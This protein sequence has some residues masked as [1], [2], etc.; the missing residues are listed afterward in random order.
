MKKSILNKDIWLSFRQSKGRFLS[1]MSLMMLGAFALVGLKT[2]S[3]D[4]EGSTSRYLAGLNTM[5]LALISDYG[6]S[7]EDQKELDQIE[8]AQVEYAYFADAVIGDSHQALRVFSKPETISKFKLVSGKYPSNDQEIALLSSF[9]DRYKIGDKIS[10]NEKSDSSQVLTQHSFTITGFV[11]SGEL[12]STINF[13]NTDVGSGTLS[14]YA[15]VLPQV[16]DSQVYTVARLTYDDL[17]GLNSFGDSYRTKLE[18]HQKALEDLVADNA[19][20]RL[21]EIQAEAQTKIQDGE[22]G[23][24]KAQQSLADA[25]NQLTDGQNQ[26]NQKQAELNQAQSQITENQGK[27]AQAASQLAAGEETLAASKAQLDEAAPQI[28][29]GQNQLAQ[30][31]AQLD[32][33]AAPLTAAQQT[34]DG[35]KAELDAAQSSLSQGQSQLAAAQSQLQAQIAAIEAQGGNPADFP[36]IAAA[37]QALAAKEAELAAGQQVLEAGQSQYQAALAQYQPQEAAYQAALGQYQEAEAQFNSKKAAYDAGLSQYQAGLASLES[38]KAEYQSGLSQLNQAK[39]QLAE[40]Q[41]QLDQAQASL[42]EKKAEFA[43]QKEKAEIQI[44]NSQAEIAKAKEDAAGL[45]LPTYHVYSRRTFPGDTEYQTTATRA[46]GISSV[47]NIFPIVL[48]LVAALVTMTTMTR[49]VNEERGNAGILRALGYKNKDVIK[50]FL[51]YGLISGVLGT[52][53]GILAGTYFLPYI[54]GRSLFQTATYPPLRLDFYWPISLLALAASLVCSVLPALYIAHKELKEKP[55]QLL[56]PKPPTKGSS[57]LLEKIG[58]IW[59]RLSFTQK[60]TAR[61]IFRYK[62][63]MFMTIFG[64]AG[65][66]ALL[67][68]GLGISSSLGGIA[69]RQFGDILQYDMVVVQK[70]RAS[71][72]EEKDLA[73]ALKSDKIS[74]SQGIYRETFSKTIKGLKDEQSISLFVSE[75]N[76]FKGFAELYDSQSKQEMKLSDDGVIISRKLATLLKVSVGDSFEL[77]SDEGKTYSLKVSGISEMYAGHF[78]FMNQAYYEKIF[79]QDFAVNAYL[80]KLKNHSN[81]DIQDQAADFMKETG[82]QTVVQ[83]LDFT[84]QI[85]AAVKSLGLVMQILTLVSILLAVVILYNLT[86]INVAERIRELS[87]IKVLGFHNKEVTLYIYRETISLSLIGILVGIFAGRALHSFLLQ[88]IAPDA[89]LFNPE[90]ALRVY[91]IPIVSIIAILILLGFMVNHNLRRVDMLEALKSVD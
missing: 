50:K 13:G 24:E 75:T 84:E 29:A 63:R 2:A 48:Y 39:S 90:V 34:L 45:L 49:F 25:Q 47:G 67:F 59:R 14:G 37:Q 16:F 5:D 1:I 77:T 44:K 86:N 42:D 27:L 55:A 10:L 19:E 71:Q 87:T 33:V 51:V 89:I 30:S 40:G 76:D 38:R 82:V 4:I 31:K 18:K 66:V 85:N 60:V 35:K 43:K 70:N 74:G 28:A 81:K 61:N 23:V 9:Q 21:E 54:L 91:L 64:V 83:N 53:L 57:I 52:I 32:A 8:G 26:I 46:N 68:A 72:A 22:V 88:M 41:Q 73:K 69:E 56:L 3:P 58:F 20:N 7:K 11:N 65:S 36:E 79:A 6:I 12:G 62:L 15:L 78:V 80:V 17:K